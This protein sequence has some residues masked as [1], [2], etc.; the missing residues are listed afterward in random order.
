MLS[1]VCSLTLVCCVIFMIFLFADFFSRSTS[2]KNSFMNTIEYVLSGLIWVQ[3]VCKGY[4]QMTNVK[5]VKK[6]RSVLRHRI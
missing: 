5:I 2:S 3:T 4:Q 1:H 6:V